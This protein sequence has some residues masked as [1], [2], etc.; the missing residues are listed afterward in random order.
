MT[1][2]FRKLARKDVRRGFRCGVAELDLFF[3]KYAGQ[4]QYKHDLGVTSVAVEGGV[5][6]GF[7][8]VSPCHV[9]VEALS[10]EQRDG[11]PP[12]TLPMLRLA[13]LAV[14]I[15]AQGRG[16][17]KVLLRGVFGWR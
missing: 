1:I 11:L 10:E 17:G 8:T 6:L 15:T 12:Y 2:E 3:E 14:S 13:R 7:A 4:N 5:I 16:V 9:E